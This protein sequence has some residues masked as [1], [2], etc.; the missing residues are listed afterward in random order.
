[1]SDLLNYK[2]LYG[3]KMQ[4]VKAPKLRCNFN[5]NY[6]PEVRC[7]SFSVLCV[8]FS[9]FGSTSLSSSTTGL[10]SS[11]NIYRERKPWYQNSAWGTC[12]FPF[13]RYLNLKKRIPNHVM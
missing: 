13:Q 1:M 2:V 6:L 10:L 4:A 3:E 5:E 8:F 9:G 7:R 12:G 11:C